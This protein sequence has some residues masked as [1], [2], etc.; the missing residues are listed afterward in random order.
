M[1]LRAAERICTGKAIA[2]RRKAVVI[3]DTQFTSAL[4]Y[5]LIGLSVSDSLSLSRQPESDTV[6]SSFGSQ[7]EKT[8]PRQRVQGFFFPP[9]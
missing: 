1:D 9:T 5:D 3:W 7:E 2:W 4:V 6:I 8:L